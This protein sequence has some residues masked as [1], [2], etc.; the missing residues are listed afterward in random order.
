MRQR[1][2]LEFLKDYDFELSYHPGKANVVAD[3]LS[4]KSLHMSSLM[5]KELD[6]IEEFRD[7]SLVCETTP[8]S[9]KL[10]MSKL[11]NVFLEDVKRGQKEDLSLV[12]RLT[13]K[14]Q[15]E[16]VDF[17]ID[18]FGVIRF[19]GRVCVPDVP[20]I[21]K[22]ILEEGHR[23]GLS[24]HPGATKMYQDLKKLFWWPK[25]K[26]EVA[27]FVYA[28]L[29]CQKSKVEHQKSSDLLQPMFV[30]KWK[31]DSIAMDFTGT[32]VHK[33]AEI[34]VEQI[35]KLHGIPSSIV[36]DRDPRF[37]SRFWESLQ[38]AVGTKLRMSSAYHPQTD[39][40]LEI[41]IQ[42]LEDL[43]RASLYG[44]RCRTP[45]CWYETGENVVLGLEIV[46]ETTEKI[47]MIQEKMKATQSRR[48]SYL[49]KKRKDVEFQ[50]GDHVF[51][52]VTPTT[53]I[54]RALKSKKLTSKFIGLKYISDPSH[55]IVSDNVQV[56]D[57]LTVE[58]IPLRIEEVNFRG[59]K[60][61]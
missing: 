5:M 36:S 16:Q 52:R 57:N 11:T 54:G 10:G 40:Q 38:E 14:K 51:L 20:E 25:M 23:S 56:R 33:L 15:G 26:K 58:A 21:K 44:R 13:P 3:A 55:V 1:R 49:D 22:S 19:R 53:G 48:K 27:E 32:L 50:E 4:R 18:E 2:C 39:G 59:R 6:L 31:Y 37:T 30:L 60:F 41:T 47:K 24:I 7:L 46:Q 8:R 17:N 61:F 35:V 43:L 9:V 45:L 42:S 34:Y 12:D 28:C 29:V